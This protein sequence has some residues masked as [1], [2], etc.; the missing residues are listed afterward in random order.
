MFRG[1]CGPRQISRGASH[2]PKSQLPGLSVYTI[3]IAIEYGA[4]FY[5]G[6]HTPG[7]FLQ[8]LF[9]NIAGRLNSS[10]SKLCNSLTECARFAELVRRT[11]HNT[12]CVRYDGGYKKLS[13]FSA[14]Y[15][16]RLEIDEWATALLIY[17]VNDLS[18][19]RGLVKHG[20]RA[21]LRSMTQDCI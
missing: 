5:L 20:L 2:I 21:C 13:T 11:E 10:E 14:K 6:Q 18:K 3:G 9:H 16:K 12:E 4:L 19:G 1:A 17:R 7:R 15:H 8:P